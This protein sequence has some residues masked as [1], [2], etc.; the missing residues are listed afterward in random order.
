MD[1][2][3]KTCQVVSWKDVAPERLVGKPLPNEST[4]SV[5]GRKGRPLGRINALAEESKGRT[6][7]RT[8]PWS[9]RMGLDDSRWF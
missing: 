1:V 7:S 8:F 3:E 6:R 5:R 9:L 4:R 2:A